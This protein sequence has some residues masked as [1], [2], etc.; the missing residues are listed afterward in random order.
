MKKVVKAT[1]A[2]ASVNSQ[3]TELEKLVINQVTKF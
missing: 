2:V 3:I 1:D